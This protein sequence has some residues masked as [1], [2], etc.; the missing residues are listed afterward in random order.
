[1]P[2]VHQHVD[3]EDTVVWSGKP[4]A[5][6]ICGE[7]VLMNMDRGFFYSLDDIGSEI[8]RSLGEPV[9][10]ASLCQSLAAK[11]HAET[12]TVT[13]DVLALLNKLLDHE[14]IVVLGG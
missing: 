5:S 4:L 6:E 11:Y 8:W 3:L 7:V 1:M 14:L 12:A 9:S 13:A 10:V 2:P